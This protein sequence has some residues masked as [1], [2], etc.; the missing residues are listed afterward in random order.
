L[1]IHWKIIAE[2]RIS[3]EDA[4]FESSHRKPVPALPLVLTSLGM[5]WLP[6]FGTLV[7]LPILIAQNQATQSSYRGEIYGTVITTEGTPAKGLTLNAQPLGVILATPL[8]WTKTNDAGAYRFDHLQWGR[9]TVYAEDKEAGYSIFSTGPSGLGNWPEVEITAGHPS[10]EFNV[11]LPPPAGFLIFQLANRSTGAAISGVEVT[12]MSG[13]ATPKLIFS[14]GFSLPD[15]ILVPSDRDLLLHVTSWG[16]KEWE[17]SVGA[18]RHIRIAPGSRVTLDVQL[19]A[20]NSITARIRAADPEKYQGIHDGKDWRNPYL[21][22]RA[23]GIEIVGVSDGR[24]PLT[25]DAAL[26]ILEGLPASAWPY[27]RVVAIQDV[28][29]VTSENQH[30]HVIENR[31]TLNRRLGDLGLIVGLWPSA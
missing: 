17:E 12:V 11:H 20:S 23:E 31:N 5:R 29:I 19:E 7:C 1:K 9:Y 26:A 27:G 21:I 25:I 3:G 4:V 22:V 16:F 13:D 18:G 24:N 10:A 2:W 15:P 14:G 6:L 28:G 30:S 8:A